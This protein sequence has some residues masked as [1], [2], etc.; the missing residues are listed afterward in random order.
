MVIL[1][2]VMINFFQRDYK[3]GVNEYQ[4]FLRWATYIFMMQFTQFLVTS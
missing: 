3:I 2:F 4:I 1:M